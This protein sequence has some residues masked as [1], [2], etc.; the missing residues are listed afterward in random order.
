MKSYISIIIVVILPFMFSSCKKE[1]PTHR[2]EEI[3]ND[4]EFLGNIDAKEVII[5]VQGGPITS[6]TP[7]IQEFIFV[8]QTTDKHWVN[9]HQVQTKY[10]ELFI[11]EEITFEQAKAYD[12]QSVDMLKKVIDHF[13]NKGKKVYVYGGSFGAF[14]VQELIALHGIDVA[15][16]YLI[17][18][19]R[20][21]IDEE[22]WKKFS[23]GNFAEF[24]FDANGTP[25]V[26][27]YPPVSA[28]DIR[29]RNMNKL[30]AGLGFNRYTKRWA[31]IADLSKITYVYAALD[32]QVGPLT[33]EEKLFLLSKNAKVNQVRSSDHTAGYNTSLFFIKEAFG[34]R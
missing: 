33:N 16:A 8:S 18:V 7:T 6:L 25:S 10:P 31:H 17:T 22:V 2:F 30:A 34:L 4:A 11:N 23:E 5:N 15:D 28:S 20:L 14:I 1:T 19:G 3:Q 24:E 32:E 26:K 27:V 21:D 13:K 9:V 12:L 29:F